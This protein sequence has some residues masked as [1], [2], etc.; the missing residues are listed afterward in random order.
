MQVCALYRHPIKSHGREAIELVHLIQ[1]QTMPWD[2][3][4]A[5]THEAAKF[6]ADNPEWASC[7]NFMIGSRTPGLVGIWAKLDTVNRRVTL[8]H[9]DLEPLTFAPD[10]ATD[11]ARFLDWVAPLCPAD[12]AAPTAIVAAPDRGMTD[13]P[14]PS[15]SIMN[16]ASHRAVA[17][18]LGVKM[19]LPG[20]NLAGSGATSSWDRLFCGFA[21]LSS[22][23]PSPIPTRS[24]AS[25]TRQLLIS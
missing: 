25:A 23:A 7:H 8:T 11:A 3:V 5:V 18:A 6:D 1:G 2:R 16:A 13:S 24:P 17:D 10:D 9:Q 22:G 20:P 15:V 14:Y 12:R 19:P 21:N 4:W